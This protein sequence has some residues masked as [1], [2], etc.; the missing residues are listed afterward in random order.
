MDVGLL[1]E[2]LARL[3]AEPLDLLFGDGLAAEELFDLPAAQADGNARDGLD[4][5]ACR[6]R[7]DA[8]VE[9]TRHDASERPA[10]RTGE[11][12]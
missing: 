10:E 5:R 6:E 3:E 7:L 4:G 9:V 12:R 8:L 11:V 2:D 1:D